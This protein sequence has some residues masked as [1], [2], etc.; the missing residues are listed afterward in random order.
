MLWRRWTLKTLCQVKEASLKIPHMVWL[1]LYEMSKIGKS[2]ETES[3]IM[4][5]K[6]WGVSEFGGVVENEYW[7]VAG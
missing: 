1:Q 6:N 2:I 3:S 7:W 4:V 5:A